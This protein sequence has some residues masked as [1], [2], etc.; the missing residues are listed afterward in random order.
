MGV[1]KNNNNKNNNNS[2]RRTISKKVKIVTGFVA[3]YAISMVVSCLLLLQHQEK[4]QHQQHHGITNI[5]NNRKQQIRGGGIVVEREEERRR[6]V[7]E[8]GSSSN[9]NS[10]S[11]SAG[12]DL[13]LDL[14]RVLKSLHLH[15]LPAPS[16]W[17]TKKLTVPIDMN[18][19]TNT[20]TNTVEAIDIDI[21]PYL[22]NEE[23]TK[24]QHLCGKF[25]YSTVYKAVRVEGLLS[26]P[27]VYV[28]TGDI[29]NM[30]IRDSMVQMSLYL[31]L[32]QQQPWVRLLVE[33]AIRRNAFNIIQDPYANSYNKNWINPTSLPLKERVLGRGGFVASRNYELDSG[34]YYLNFLYD[35]YRQEDVY[36]PD[37]LLVEPL[38]F[39]SVQLVVKT[40][41]TEQNHDT[42]SSYRYFELEREGKGPPTL[43]TGMT[44]SGFRPSDDRCQYGYNI[45]SNIHAASALEKIL[46]LNAKV[47]QQAGLHQRV[48][49]LLTEIEEGIQQYGIIRSSTDTGSLSSSAF[50]YAYEVDGFG[51]ML[52]NFDDANIPSLLSIPLL[53]W[54]K[55]DPEIYM[56]TRRQLLSSTTNTK[57]Y[58]NGTLYQG[59]GS[60]HT[61]PQSVWPMSFIVQGL[62]E[63]QSVEISTGSSTGHQ[64]TNTATQKKSVEQKMAFQMQQLLHSAYGD[65]MHE[66]VHVSKKNQ[67][68]RFWFEWV[69][70]CSIITF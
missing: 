52:A 53:G 2:K 30:W 67:Y 69:R 56:T 4:Q 21:R 48:T 32:P 37:V 20:N 62:T 44:W 64:N 35:Y 7:G 61:P 25:F 14:D 26:T 51:N 41:I 40:W 39:E 50:Y 43:Y 70:F 11:S 18:T 8:K 29:D 45:P 12:F 23:Q 46:L 36:Q 33:G 63:L 54:T 28:G 58:H 60:P 65:A 34:A 55:Y 5:Y 59:I 17:S 57:T 66:S 68:T 15:V 24:I 16:I 27:T 38:I 6:V 47:W 42:H 9:S 13:D 3:A 10:S 1:N 31:N 49:K 19:N 22:T